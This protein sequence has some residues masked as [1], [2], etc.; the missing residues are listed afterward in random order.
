MKPIPVRSDVHNALLAV[1]HIHQRGIEIIADSWRLLGAKAV[2]IRDIDKQCLASSP[3]IFKDAPEWNDGS[4]VTMSAPLVVEGQVVGQ[5]GVLGLNGAYEKTRLE[6]SASLISHL[7]SLQLESEKMT[8]E[9][10]EQAK[11]KAELD[12]TASIQLQLLPQKLPSIAGLDLYAHSRPAKRV[13]GDFYTFNT[14]GTGHLV[15]TIGDVSGKGLPAALLMNMTRTVLHGVA[16]F[17]PLLHPKAVLSRVNEDLYDDFTEV[18]MFVTACVGCYDPATRQ[19]LYANAGHSPVVYCPINGSAR[20]LQA[21]GPA[22]GVLPMMQSENASL[23]FDSGDV[24]V[25]ATDG[26]NEAQNSSGEL[27]G[28]ER[29]RILIEELRH[30]SAK[31]IAEGLFERI[32]CFA[33]GCDQFD[34]Q[35]LIVMK[36]I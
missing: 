6:A 30:C 15:L 23:R 34:D 27:F 19:L 33:E 4:D 12:L 10:I 3:R 9:R 8:A 18:G 25:L 29:L 32:T 5:L 21:D 14:H 17:I 7:I 24:L 16:R 28:Y 1:L 26:L 11:L 31:D 13:G 22:I 20:I 2:C 36:G 35:T